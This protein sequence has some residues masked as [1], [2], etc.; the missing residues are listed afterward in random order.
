MKNVTPAVYRVI[1]VIAQSKDGM[2]RRKRGGVESSNTLM[3]ERIL[4]ARA[5]TEILTGVQQE[6][7]SGM[8]DD[9]ADS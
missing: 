8:Q 7:V 3:S 5:V 1:I 2:S 9:V 4:R 6:H